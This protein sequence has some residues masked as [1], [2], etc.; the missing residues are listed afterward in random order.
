M[1]GKAKLVCCSFRTDI[2]VS[3]T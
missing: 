2:V 3:L 1:T